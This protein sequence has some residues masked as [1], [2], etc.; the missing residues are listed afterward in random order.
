M[1]MTAAGLFG[2]RLLVKSRWRGS[3][4]LTLFL[5]RRMATL[6]SVRVPADRGSVFVD[7]RELSSHGLF[8]GWLPE[9]VERSWVT[10]VVLPGH[11]AFD[12]GAHWGLYS[13]LL[14]SLVGQKGQ[15]FSFEPCPRVLPQLRRTVA[16]LLN[17]TLIEAGLSDRVGYGSLEVPAD[18]SM[19]SLQ[20]DPVRSFAGQNRYAIETTT[21]DQL[22]ADSQIG[23]ADF[24]K[25]DVEGAEAL[26]FRG[27]A[28]LL[29]RTNAP[30]LL[31]ENSP[32]AMRL[33]GLGAGAAASLLT[34]LPLPRYRLFLLGQGGTLDPID[35]MPA[36]YTNVLAVPESRKGLFL[37]QA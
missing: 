17:V 19:S 6:Q 33:F 36:G 7:L 16:P 32:A 9:A 25:C 11:I 24:I 15:V 37:G 13:V 4:R 22:F 1:G 23:T 31:F 35:V 18:A 12:V 34:D 20:T 3:T 28:Q 10:R 30:V 5:A 2:L 14:A 29:D 27:A 21:L 8:A 26:V